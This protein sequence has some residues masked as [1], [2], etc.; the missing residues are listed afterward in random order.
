MDKM[1]I[2]G[3]PEAIRDLI[4]WGVNFTRKADD[5]YDLTRHDG[6]EPGR[7]GER[8]L[9]KCHSHEPTPR[10]TIRRLTKDP[11]PAAARPRVFETL[12][13]RRGVPPET[14]PRGAR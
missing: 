10:A 1:V 12:P 8:L 6:L 2:E 5:S 9:R 4:G 7:T 3:G 14:T 13:G 11:C